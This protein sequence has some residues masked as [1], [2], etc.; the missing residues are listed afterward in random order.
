MYLIE[1]S[2]YVLL[3]SENHI[4]TIMVIFNWL[5]VR[6]LPFKGKISHEGAFQFSSYSV[7]LKCYICIIKHDVVDISC[8][9]HHFS[10][11]SVAT[12]PIKHNAQV[13]HWNTFMKSLLTPV[14]FLWGSV[15]CRVLSLNGWCS[16]TEHDK[17]F[18]IAENVNC[19]ISH[20]TITF[21]KFYGLRMTHELRSALTAHFDQKTPI[22]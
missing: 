3:W 10:A 11:I 2:N 20:E 9:F 22:S 7:R 6:K 18:K 5:L 19:T 21:K 8:N 17:R 15:C 14:L 12:T 16:Q 4:P 1:V 13:S